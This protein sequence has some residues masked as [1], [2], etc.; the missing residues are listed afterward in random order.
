MLSIQSVRLSV[1][2]TR[3]VH[4]NG[5][6]W[7]PT[8]IPDEQLVSVY[9]STDTSSRQCSTDTETVRVQIGM[10]MGGNGNCFSGI[11]WNGIEVSAFQ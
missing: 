4:G 1:C 6:D 2:H 11:N 8:G 3:D 7:D 9:M 5:N 10:G